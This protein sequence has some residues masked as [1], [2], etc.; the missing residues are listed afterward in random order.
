MLVEAVRAALGELDG[1]A[2]CTVEEAARVLGIG[3]SAAYAAARARELPTLRVG[4]RLVVPV[5]ALVALLLGVGTFA[6]P[7][8]NIVSD[9]LPDATTE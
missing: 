4:R 6:S 1:R 3:R 2:T 5:P 9:R 8:S 7:T